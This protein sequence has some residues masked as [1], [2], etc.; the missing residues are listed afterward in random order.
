MHVPVKAL[1]VQI[2]ADL[3]PRLVVPT[4]V[5]A[6]STAQV[7]ELLPAPHWQ[8]NGGGDRSVPILHRSCE[9]VIGLGV[10]R[11][12]GGVGGHWGGAGGVIG[13]G[14]YWDGGVGTDRLQQID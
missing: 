1:P 5:A 9:G 12:W 4:F 6:A 13:G 11:Y 2:P 10:R 8:A 14:G 3:I 7:P